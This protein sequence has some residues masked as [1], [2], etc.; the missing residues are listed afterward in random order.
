LARRQGNN[1]KPNVSAPNDKNLNNYT[2]LACGDKVTHD[3]FGQGIV[4]EIKGNG[5][6][7]EVVVVF[8][9][10]GIKRLLLE[11]AHLKKLS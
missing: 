8:N 5:S 10:A 1:L 9:S 11:Y 3:K 6:N 2:E 4:V 7:Q